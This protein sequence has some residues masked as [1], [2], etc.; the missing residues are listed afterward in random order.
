MKSKI[1]YIILILFCLSFYKLEAQ[2]V[3]S[4]SVSQQVVTK[5]AADSFYIK[6]DYASAINIYETILSTKG[7]SADI[8]YNLGNCYY[9]S[10]N[11]AKSILNYERAYLLAP[12]D[13]AIRF[14]LEM[15]RN[16][17]VD[18]INTV[19]DFFLI[20]WINSI[21]NMFSTDS[22]AGGAVAL[23]L[24]T[25]IFF[26]VYIFSKLLLWKKIGFI[27]ALVLLLCSILANIFAFQQKNKLL[28]RQYAIIMTPSVTAKSTPDEGGTDLFIL[29]EGHKVQLKDQT[30]KEWYEIQLEDGNIGWIPK[31]A[32]EII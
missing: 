3:D 2:N 19:D 8:Y 6:E 9:K 10:G 1:I 25:L 5:M 28:N 22:W 31:E 20:S 17:T 27:G 7:E 11:I 23:F 21:R 18:K 29:H 13:N 4:I 26:L 16:K 30:M 32:I 15:A 14:N 24:L 12:G